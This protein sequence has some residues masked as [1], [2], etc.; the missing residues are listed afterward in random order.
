MCNNIA[1]LKN[2]VRAVGQ[3][4]QKQHSL[5]PNPL[6]LKHARVMTPRAWDTSQ[7]HKHIQDLLDWHLAVCAAVQLHTKW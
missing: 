2:L 6:V 5:S 3:A 4:K 1:F 7:E